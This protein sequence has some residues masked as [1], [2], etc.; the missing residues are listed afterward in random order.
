MTRSENMMENN[1]QIKF[2]ARMNTFKNI[3]RIQ[4]MISQDIQKQPPVV[5]Y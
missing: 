3:I 4:I 2:Y 1:N 5:F